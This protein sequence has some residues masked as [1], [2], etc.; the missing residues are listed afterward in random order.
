MDQ[1]LS[2][3]GQRLVPGS[4]VGNPWWDRAGADFFSDFEL[5]PDA[6]VVLE[7]HR[8]PGIPD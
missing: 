4:A 1:C 2:L 6:Q 3:C 8:R 5:E 7:L